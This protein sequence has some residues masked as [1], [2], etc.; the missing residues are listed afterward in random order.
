MLIFI[1]YCGICCPRF[2]VAT[3]LDYYLIFLSLVFTFFINSIFTF[4]LN[5][6]YLFFVFYRS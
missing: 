4:T 5:L 1:I 3:Q 6:C 2:I